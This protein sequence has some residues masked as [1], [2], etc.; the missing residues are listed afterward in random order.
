MS[1]FWIVLL[2]IASV[3]LGTGLCYYL[4]QK[5]SDI[6]P[7]HWIA[8]HIACP[9]LRI[10]ILI[11]IVSLIYPLIGNGDFSFWEIILQPDHFNHLINIL[12]FGSLIMAFLPL[13]N[14]PIFSLPIQSC[15]TVALVFNWQNGN[16][17]G[18]SFSYLPGIAFLA[19]L[20]L[21]MALAYFVTRES[22]IGLSRLL[23]RQFHVSGS[24]RLVADAIYLLLQIPVIWM[25]CSYL[26]TQLPI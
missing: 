25:Y 20:I 10:L 1:W 9:I 17:L 26:Q 5:T 14:H 15:L 19:K 22:S 6:E 3:T 16:L 8:E 13:V 12:F 21:Y 18:E 2:T 11:I 24:I 4:L 23:D 7:T